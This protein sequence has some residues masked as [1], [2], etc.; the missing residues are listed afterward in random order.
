MGCGGGGVLVRVRA[1]D[2]RICG[3]FSLYYIRFSGKIQPARAFYWS[4][5]I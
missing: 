1:L 3:V 2:P 4:T 5:E